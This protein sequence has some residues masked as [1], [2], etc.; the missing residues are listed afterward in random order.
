MFC[1]NFFP[2][3]QNVVHGDITADNL[4]VAASGIVKIGDFS[5]NQVVKV[6]HCSF[7]NIFTLR[8]ILT[9]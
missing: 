9:W 1:T 7:R 4:L 3:S 2:I 6:M 5:V 8:W